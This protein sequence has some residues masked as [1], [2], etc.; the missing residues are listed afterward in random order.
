PYAGTKIA[1]DKQPV[2]LLIE[3][4]Y[5]TGVRPLTY[6]VEIAADT[7]FTNKVFTRDGIAPGDGG[8]TSLRLPDPLAPERT[9][10][11]R[12]RALDG[13]NTGNFSSMSTFAVFTPIVIQ[14]PTLVSPI[15]NATVDNLRPRFTIGNAARSG[16]VGAISYLIEV[17]DS[18]SFAN[19]VAS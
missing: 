6:T 18:D 17:S 13:A 9:Y 10:F 14:P 4:A 2:T 15:E 16:P 12:V 8:R 1:V 3:N 7:N 5:T 19:K 11:W